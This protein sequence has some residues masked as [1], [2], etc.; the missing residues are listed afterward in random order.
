MPGQQPARIEKIGID[1]LQNLASKNEFEDANFGFL[2]KI[3]PQTTKETKSKGYT[4]GGRS[5]NFS[6]AQTQQS[7]HTQIRDDMQKS[8]KACQ[9]TDRRIEYLVKAKL[10]RTQKLSDRKRAGGGSIRGSTVHVNTMREANDWASSSSIANLR[11]ASNDSA[12]KKRNMTFDAGRDSKID[13]KL[14]GASPARNAI[15]RQD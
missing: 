7:Y 13:R 10:D 14:M 1:K 9:P 3:A 11:N 8:P 15:L 12:F 5:S 6:P 4:F 2:H